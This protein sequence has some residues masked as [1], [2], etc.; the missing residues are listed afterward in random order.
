M[1]QIFDSVAIL[2][3][4]AKSLGYAINGIHIDSVDT[5]RQARRTLPYGPIRKDEL[6]KKDFFVDS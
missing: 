4:N 3:A 1:F 5:Y 6:D 2:V